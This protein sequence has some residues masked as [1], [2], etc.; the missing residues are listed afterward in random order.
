MMK[1]QSSILYL[2]SVF[3][4]C[5][6]RTH[7]NAII[8]IVLMFFVDRE[9]DICTRF[10]VLVLQF[11]SYSCQNSVWIEIY[12]SI[13]FL[14]FWIYISCFIAFVLASKKYTIQVITVMQVYS[15]TVKIQI[16]KTV[17][18]YQVTQTQKDF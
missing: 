7:F 17:V 13:Q 16:L 8:V 4:Y 1:F 10:D 9:W 5:N 14:Y 18:F 3:I 12:I 2:D 11:C 15:R 6:Y